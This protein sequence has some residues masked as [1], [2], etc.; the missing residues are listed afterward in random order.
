MRI[1]VIRQ[2]FVASGGAELYLRALIQGL[3]AR[4]HEVHVLAN[5]WRA[6]PAEPVHFHRV[7]MVRVTAFARALSFALSARKQVARAGCDLVLSLERTLRHDV[8]TAIDGCHREWLAQRRRHGPAWKGASF[9]MNPLHRTLLAL[10][11]RLFHPEHTRRVIVISRR[12]AQEITRHYG[13]PAGRIHLIYPGVDLER[14]RPGPGWDARATGAPS[15]PGRN[16]GFQ[17]LFAGSGF[18]RKG[19]PW[20]LQAL[21]RLP[22]NTR[23]QVVGKGNVAAARRLA[24]ELG[25]G[26][27]VEFLGYDLDSARVFPEADA[28]VHPAMYEAFG[29][30]CLEA[31]AC[32]LPVITSEV[33]GASELIEPGRTGAVVVRPDD[34]AGL[35][36]AIQPFLNRDRLAA[37]AVECRRVAEAHPVSRNV[38]ETLAVLEQALSTR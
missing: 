29:I 36:A 6:E 12:G 30:V 28:L 8:Y 27:R 25:V 38:E 4:G 15:V 23:L 24:G 5:V 21:A 32:G 20:C 33:T 3:L 17:L 31:L 22:A 16:S 26:D 1:A 2:R 35:A 18:E 7:P 9:A 11:R 37:A 34:I 10:E 19:L 13:Y 14:F